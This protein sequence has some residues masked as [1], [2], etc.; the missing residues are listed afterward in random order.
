MQDRDKDIEM[1]TAKML[2]TL[3]PRKELILRLRFGIGVS[4]SFPHEVIAEQLGITPDEVVELETQAL[5]DLRGQA[6]TD[7]ADLGASI[8]P[9]STPPEPTVE[10]IE[11]I[12]KVKQISPEFIRHLKENNEDLEKINEVVAEWLVAELLA[13]Q[14]LDDVELVGRNTL[15]SA[16]IFAT[17]TIQPS[18]LKL[19]IF[20]EV[21]RRKNKI[22]IE[23]I[24]TVYGAMILEQPVFGCNAVMIVST[25]GFK[26]LRKISPDQ[27][28]L[29]GV[30][31]RDKADLIK[32]IDDYKP[33]KDG[34]WLPPWAGN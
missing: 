33:N 7:F 13:Q 31:L 28:E 29:R 14:G 10:L 8:H 25:G 32:W 5:R 1:E 27:L 20:I 6:G 30:Y 3:E 4:A 26:K 21:K 23:I 34:L 17:Q 12:E 9:I 15:T 24:N 22:G 18:G 19:R 11:V 16:D 2:T